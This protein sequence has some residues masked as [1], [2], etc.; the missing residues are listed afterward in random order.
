MKAISILN[1][2]IGPIMF[3]PSSSHTA[4]SYH[5]GRLAGELLGEPLRSARI[6]FD[7]AGS[8]AQLYREQGSDRAFVAGLL[9]WEIT[10]ERFHSALAEAE[11]SGIAVE[12]VVEPLA[13]AE[14]PN[15][16]DLSLNAAG[17]RQLHVVARS[18]GGGAI[19]I[20]RLNDM[21]VLLKGDADVVVLLPSAGKEAQVIAQLREKGIEAEVPSGPLLVANC[22]P[23]TRPVIPTQGVEEAWFARAIFYPRVGSPPWRSSTEL[24]A[25]AGDR[26][27][28]LGLSY[29]CAVLGLD[30]QD[31]LAEVLR[32][33]DVMR[34][35]VHAGLREENLPM[36]LLQPVAGQMM[37]RENAGA[38]PVGGLH[39][40][41]AARAMAVMHVNGAMG[42]LCAAPTAGSAGVL[43][44]VLVTLEEEC[45]VDRERIALGLLAAGA[46]GVVIAERATFA[47]EVAGC[48]V[49]IGASGAMAAAAVVDI[50]G[51]SARQACDAAAISLQNTMGM[52]CDLVQGIVEIPCHTRNAVAAS[53]AFVCADVVMGGYQNPVSLDETVDAVFAVGKMLPPEL[54]C[55]SKGGLAVTPSARNLRR[56]RVL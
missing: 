56:L 36:Q 5:I 33:Y 26:L 39:S 53:S 1:E 31:V 29:E 54:R 52:V 25:S 51:G 11:R 13:G 21:P 19:E 17:G 35:S 41:A 32:R 48:Q 45:G 14:H 47:A 16:V 42:R 15:T 37:K 6:A 44:G 23:H 3:G 4:G 12:F 20:V 34:E 38:L 40:R 46:V 50:F 30:E 24:L 8:Y 9:G 27:G 22:P 7:P 10:D 49:E 43:P 2:V 28:R 55:T 18:I